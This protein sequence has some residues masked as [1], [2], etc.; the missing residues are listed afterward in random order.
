ME[1]NLIFNRINDFFPFNNSV[2]FRNDNDTV[3]L[4]IT[5]PSVGNTPWVTHLHLNQSE[6]GILSHLSHANF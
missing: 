5:F 3:T 6:T 1:L 2:D 4:T